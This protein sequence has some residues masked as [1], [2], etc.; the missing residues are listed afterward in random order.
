MVFQRYFSKRFR[1]IEWKFSSYLYNLFFFLL[2]ETEMWAQ[3]CVISS[4]KCQTQA[5]HLNPSGDQREYFS[6]LHRLRSIT[7]RSFLKLKLIV[8]V[9]TKAK[10]TNEITFLAIFFSLPLC[11]CNSPNMIP[12]IKCFY[13]KCSNQCTQCSLETILLKKTI[14]E[15]VLFYVCFSEHEWTI[16]WMNESNTATKKENRKDTNEYSYIHT[17]IHT[18]TRTHR[19]RIQRNQVNM[20]HEMH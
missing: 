16:S 7:N 6:S 3:N 11:F 9:K 1:G 10:N 8:T 17:H 2:S 20:M 18:N 12:F 4:S 5:I 19:S 15:S 14:I 13:C